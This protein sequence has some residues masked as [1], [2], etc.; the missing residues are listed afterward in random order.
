MNPLTYE[1]AEQISLY[2]GMNWGKDPQWHQAYFDNFTGLLY[3]S[4][5]NYTEDLVRRAALQY[6]SDTTDKKLPPFGDF[7]AYMIKKLGA[8]QMRQAI[9]AASCASCENGTRRLFVVMRIDEESILK[10]EWV[11]R[12]D[13]SRGALNTK[14]D[15]YK[16]FLDRL[17]S[18][19]GYKCLGY[20]ES[21]P[22][23]IEILEWYVTTYSNYSGRDEYPAGVNPSEFAGMT[24]DEIGAVMFERRQQMKLKGIEAQRKQFRAAIVGNKALHY[25]K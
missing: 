2:F 14:A 17:R 10:R 8:E 7:K 18:S 23:H 19:K 4:F 12:C 1:T 25:L 16:Q 15:N 9:T 3:A 11:A 5:Q 20:R 24:L 6:I 21:D 13:C 22:H